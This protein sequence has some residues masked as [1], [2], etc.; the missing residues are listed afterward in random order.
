M[1]SLLIRNL[2]FTILLPGL[3]TI[4]LPCLLLGDL[5]VFKLS[6]IGWRQWLGLCIITLGFL[7]LVSS[8][9]RF[10][11]EGKGTLAPID[12]TK[13]LV[14]HGLYKY[15]RNPMYIGVLMILAGES[16][17]F[18]SYVMMVYM[19]VF[20]LIFTLFIMLVEEPRLKREFGESYKEY[21]K[22]VRRWL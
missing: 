13:K 10:A 11:T 7:A 12:P 9:L 21:S 3:V 15:S 22:K 16:L 5:W 8:V 17:Y 14:V 1:L 19:I 18:E 20:C 6:N 2:I 4:F